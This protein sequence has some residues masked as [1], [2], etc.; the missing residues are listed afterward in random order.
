MCIQALSVSF[1]FRSWIS[2]VS[3]FINHE[4]FYLWYDLIRRYSKYFSYIPDKDYTSPDH[5]DRSKKKRKRKHLKRSGVILME[6]DSK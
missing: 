6:E 5:K 2:S 1:L 3:Q 4:Y